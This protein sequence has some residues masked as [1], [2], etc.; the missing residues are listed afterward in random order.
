MICAVREI[1]LTC[2]YTTDRYVVRD[3]SE[4]AESMG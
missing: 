4:L 3:L 1:N 2:N